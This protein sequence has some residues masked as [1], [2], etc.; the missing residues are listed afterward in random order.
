M[1]VGYRKRPYLPIISLRRRVMLENIDWV[2]YVEYLRTE[3]ILN[4]LS[5]FDPL[6]AMKEPVI[7]IPALVIAGIL[8]FFKFYR[9]LAV[10]VGIIALWIGNIHGLPDAEQELSVSSAVKFGSVCLG[11]AALWIYVFLI[12]SD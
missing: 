7:I 5:K 9:T 1:E 11:V 8:L 3:N 6:Q 4:F 12:R 10:I 2:Q